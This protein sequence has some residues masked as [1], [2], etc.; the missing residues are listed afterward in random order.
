V[1]FNDFGKTFFGVVKSRHFHHA[2]TIQNGNN[3]K[4]CG[5]KQQHYN[6]PVLIFEGQK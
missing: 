4:S 6:L 3:P 1:A 5:I 2:V